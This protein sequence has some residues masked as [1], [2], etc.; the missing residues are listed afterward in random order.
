MLALDRHSWLDQ[1]PVCIQACRRRVPAFAGMTIGNNTKTYHSSFR[2][3]PRNMIV[4]GYGEDVLDS[5]A[6]TVG[7]RLTGTHTP[8]Q[9]Y[10]STALRF[11]RDDDLGLRREPIN[12]HSR[13]DR[14]SKRY[15][16]TVTR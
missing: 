10:L 8:I 7:L 3:K 9:S 5:L 15:S 2:A 6:E 16:A 12:R 4:Q 11:G 14:E 13:L 1:E